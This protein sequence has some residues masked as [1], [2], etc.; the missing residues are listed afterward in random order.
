VFEAL[1][2]DTDDQLRALVLDHT[3]SRT[4]IR[5]ASVHGSG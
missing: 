4:L 1:H 5:M 3:A 2:I